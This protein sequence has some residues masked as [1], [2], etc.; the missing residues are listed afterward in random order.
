VPHGPLAD[1]IAIAKAGHTP[2]WET[3][4]Q[5]AEALLVTAAKTR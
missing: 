2:I 3:L 5:V 1:T 4:D